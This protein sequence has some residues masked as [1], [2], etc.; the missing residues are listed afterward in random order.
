MMV[1]FQGFVVDQGVLGVIV[2]YPPEEDIVWCFLEAAAATG[3]IEP[4]A[5]KRTVGSVW[6]WIC[7]RERGYAIREAV[8]IG[9]VVLCLRMQ[10][11]RV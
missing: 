1:H 10:R 7:E 3:H 4:Q 9:L 6:V 2:A 8:D 5:E 11:T